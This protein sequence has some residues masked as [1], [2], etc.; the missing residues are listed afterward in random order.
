MMRFCVLAVL[1]MDC[2]MIPRRKGMFERVEKKTNV[3][4]CKLKR[5]VHCSM[6]SSAS[7]TAASTEVLKE[8]KIV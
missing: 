7:T 5:K 3:A 4:V 2:R 8:R 6:W 1:E